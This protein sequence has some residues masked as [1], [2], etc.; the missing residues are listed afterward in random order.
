MIAVKKRLAVLSLSLVLVMLGARYFY[1]ISIEQKET[2]TIISYAKS[3]KTGKTSNEA[4]LLALELKSGGEV[5]E[6]IEKE[7]QEEE[8]RKRKL[9]EEQQAYNNRIESYIE[10]DTVGT[11]TNIELAQQIVEYAKQFVGNPY[12]YGGSSLTNGADCSGF[13]MSVFANFGISLPRSSSDQA[14]VGKYVSLENIQIGDLVLHGYNGY[15]SHV[16]IYIGNG[17]VVH[18]LNS[19]VG[20]V[21]TNYDIMPIITVRRVL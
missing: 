4:D 3:F 8:E 13:T 15:V 19:D 14:Y 6:E 10:T 11:T 21:I 9:E 7:L 17:Q 5:K 18:A 1:L 20:I 16:A 2:A 12:V